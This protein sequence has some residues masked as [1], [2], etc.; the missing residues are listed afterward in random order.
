MQIYC[1]D[2]NQSCWHG[3][4]TI[5]LPV[6]LIIQVQSR[7]DFFLNGWKEDGFCTPGSLEDGT[8]VSCIQASFVTDFSVQSVGIEGI[9]QAIE[10]QDTFMIN[11]VD[12]HT[13]YWLSPTLTPNFELVSLTPL[14][15]SAV[16]RQRVSLSIGIPNK[17]NSPHVKVMAGKF[18][19][20]Y[21]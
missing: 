12:I 18:T 1:G 5:E 16:N 19:A 9:M 17:N 8:K 15:L 14:N 7:E 6:T 3:T 13:G 2:I 11:S 20:Y 10:E 21:G 4:S